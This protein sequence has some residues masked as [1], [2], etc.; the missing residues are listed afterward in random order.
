MPTVSSE[1]RHAAQRLLDLARRVFV[2]LEL[3]AQVRLVGAEVEVAVAGEVEQ[4]RLL[5]AFLLG[6]LGL[7]DGHPD[8]VGRLRGRDDAFRARELQGGVERGE[9]RHRLGLD[10]ALVEQLAD[11][12]RHAV[13]AQA[14]GVQRGRDERVAERVH[15]HQRGQ[16]HGVAEVIDVVAL[17]EAGAG[18]RLHRDDADF[19]VSAGEL[20]G[21][22]GERQA[23]EVGAAARAADDDVGGVVG[24]LQLLLGL[25]ADHR[26]VHE[27]VVEHAAQRVLGVVPGGGVLDRLA[28]GDAERARRA[29]I[30]L[31]HLLAGLRVGAGAG[32]H[33]GA[34]RLH[35]DAAV[36]LLLIGHLHHVDLALQP[37]QLAGQR[38]GRA[39]LAGAG[40]GRQAGDLLLLVVVGL[41]HRGVRLVAAGRAHAFVLVVDAGRRAERFLQPPRAVERRGAPQAVD[42]AHLVGDLDPALLA[43]LLL[44]QFHGEQRGEVRRADRLLGAGMQHRRRRRLEVGLD[45]VPLG[46]DVLLVE[47]ELRALAIDLGGHTDLLGG[48]Q[49]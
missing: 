9:L 8:G 27:H 20:V 28:D 10:H 36:G 44:D 46:R 1:L 24:L 6:A 15:L 21:R 40:L 19:L 34:P 22:E 25:Q 2:V 16:P 11:Q 17:G 13:V 32:H 12:R 5:L 18:G 45:V 49:R 31:E 26:L 38:Q 42:V 29:G 30:L 41:G 7:V 23:G 35:H 37:E 39:P 3:A 4:D 33:L 47:R 14:A 48:R 43:D